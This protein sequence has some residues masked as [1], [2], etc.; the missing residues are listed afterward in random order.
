MISRHISQLCL[1]VVLALGVGTAGFFVGKGLVQFRQ[2]RKIIQAKGIG[3][4]EVMADYAIWKIPF[5]VTQKDFQAAKLAYE[6]NLSIIQG[7]LSEN[8]FTLKDIQILVPNI[9]QKILRDPQ[10]ELKKAEES[11][12][13]TGTVLIKTSQVK[14]VEAASEKTFQL[15]QKGVWLRSDPYTT[16]PRYIIRDF[17]RLRPEIFAQAIESAYRM[18]QKLAE[19]SGVTIGKILSVD[20]GNFSIRS[21]IGNENEEA[22]PEKKVRVVSYVNYEL[23]S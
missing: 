1:G 8:G 15:L 17:D 23:V 13:I 19:K 21:R 10:D 6:E 3:E 2:A 16:N 18:A 12:E 11:Y 4:Q 14:Q 5:L 9:E 20:Q 7:F 22:Y